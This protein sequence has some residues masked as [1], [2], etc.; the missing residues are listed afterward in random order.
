MLCF[1]LSLSVM[2]GVLLN[3]VAL[4]PPTLWAQGMNASLAFGLTALNT[5]VQAGVA[6]V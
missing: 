5:Y 3:R 6:R 4:S 2:C 1:L